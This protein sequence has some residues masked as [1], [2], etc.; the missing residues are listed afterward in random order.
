L[1]KATYDPI[2]FSPVL[3][4]KYTLNEKSNLRFTASKTS[5]KPR[6]RE[7]LPFRYQDGDG[8]FTL[9]NKDLKNTTNYNVDLKYELLPYS[10]FHY[11]RLVVLENSFRTRLADFVEGTSTGFLTQYDNFDEATIY[12]VELETNFG[13]DLHFWRFLYD[14]KNY[15]RG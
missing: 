10:K 2:D 7:I 11:C 6:F 3:N 1:K 9:G 4:L 14:Q 12:G 13:L 15:L 8:N 5:T